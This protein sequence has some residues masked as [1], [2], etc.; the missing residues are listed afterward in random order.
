MAFS[1]SED[2]LAFVSNAVPG[3]EPTGAIQAL[4]GGNLNYVWRVFGEE[5]SLIVKQAPPYIAQAPDIPLSPQRILIE[6]AALRLFAKPPLQDII[7]GHL[8]PPGLI[9]TDEKNYA[10]IL[11]DVGNL[12]SLDIHPAT[13]QRLGTN[14]GVFIG[15]LHRVTF[16]DEAI[17]KAIDNPQIQQSRLEVQYAQARRILTG[18]GASNA[19][20]LGDKAEQLGEK[21]LTKGKCLIMGDLWPRSVL[22]GPKEGQARIIDWEFA[23]FGRPAQDVAHF[24]AHLWMLQHCAESMEKKRR[25]RQLQHAFVTSYR[26]ALGPKMPLIFDEEETEDAGVHFG[27]EILARTIGS[28]QNGYLYEG[29]DHSHPKIKEA[30]HVAVLHLA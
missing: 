27:A 16:Q 28:F 29:L 18:F 21:Y 4:S 3:F 22:I 19:A 7:S 11:E 12:K 25:F 2:L 23:H 9:Y 5:Q 10:L 8:R 26:A 6:A 1:S 13:G 14:L 24:L 20:E 15:Q 30:V 17:A